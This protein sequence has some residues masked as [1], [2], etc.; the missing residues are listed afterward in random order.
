MVAD[1]ISFKDMQK[2]DFMQIYNWIQGSHVNKWWHDPKDWTEFKSKFEGKL[3][4][5]DRGCFLIYIE[6]NPI[7]YIQYYIANKFP[8]WQNEPDGTYGMDLFIVDINYI[9]KGY[10]H[11]IVFRFIE[12]IFELPQANRIII[13]PDVNNIAAIKTYEKAGF[14][15]YKQSETEILMETRTHY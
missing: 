7:G 6:N 15:K 5:K 8:E 13:N 4:S 14:K 12:K 1:S 9:G 11:K 2:S 3:K 10:G